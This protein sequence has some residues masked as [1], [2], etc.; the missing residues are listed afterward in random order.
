MVFCTF[1][2]TRTFLPAVHFILLLDAQQW[3]P[4]LIGLIFACLQSFKKPL[5]GFWGFSTWW[6]W[7]QWK[8]YMQE[9]D[10]F[11]WSLLR[12]CNSSNLKTM[13]NEH[14]GHWVIIPITHWSW[15]TSLPIHYKYFWELP[16]VSG[17][18]GRKCE[19]VHWMSIK[20]LALYLKAEKQ[21]CNSTELRGIGLLKI[22]VVLLQKTYLQWPPCVT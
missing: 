16:K 10:V 14:R 18:L 6:L 9:A 5:W 2:Q 17:V 4:H 7:L 12:S 15:E 13:W 8:V 1:I 22:L 20:S 19:S 11:G 21:A 3:L